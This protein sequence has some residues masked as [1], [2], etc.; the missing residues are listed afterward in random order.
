MSET[1]QKNETKNTPNHA[2]SA[3]QQP[4]GGGAPDVSERR[5]PQAPAEQPAAP[6]F[7]QGKPSGPQQGP[8]R[9]QSLFAAKGRKEGEAPFGL[10][11]KDAKQL[12]SKPPQRI[13]IIS[14]LLFLLVAFFVGSQ[15]MNLMNTKETDALITSEFVQAVEQDRVKNVVYDAGNYTVSGSY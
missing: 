3:P 2:P 7:E 12:M 6:R 15:M 4:A 10:D 14:A 5:A 8:A 13:S 9:P 1:P 11:P